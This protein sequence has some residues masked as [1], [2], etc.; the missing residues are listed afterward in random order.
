MYEENKLTSLSW[1]AT[2]NNY[3]STK[4]V[5]GT[6]DVQSGNSVMGFPMFLKRRRMSAKLAAVQKLE[7]KNI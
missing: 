5:R 2:S 1:I 7:D 4:S 6:L 3:V